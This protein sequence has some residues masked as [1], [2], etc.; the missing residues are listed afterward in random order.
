V[1]DAGAATR[2]KSRTSYT[3]FIFFS[4]RSILSP[5][6]H[7]KM[8]F[9]IV[10]SIYM[11]PFG[12]RCRCNNEGKISSVYVFVL[13]RYLFDSLLFQVLISMLPF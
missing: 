12:D 9:Y 6:E 11:L 10:Y 3:G 7:S 4:L 1:I 5:S 13:G 8:K 2:E